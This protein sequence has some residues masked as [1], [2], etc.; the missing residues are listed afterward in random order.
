MSAGPQIKRANIFSPSKHTMAFS[1]SL[2][3]E[4]AG[5][6]PITDDNLLLVIRYLE[7]E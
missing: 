1:L 2:E 7:T 6:V 5:F 4:R 3:R